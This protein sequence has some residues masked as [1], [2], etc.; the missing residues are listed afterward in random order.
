MSFAARAM[1]RKMFPPPTTTPT[2]VPARAMAAISVARSLTRSGS[3]PKEA[4]PARASPLNFRRM[5]S[6]FAMAGAGLRFGLG[7]FGTGECVA[8]F[9]PCESR[10]RDVFA[11]LGDF[12]LDQLIDGNRVFLDERLL[13]EADLFVELG[14]AAFHDLVDHLLGLAF[15]QGAG[16]LD[17]L[18]FCQRGRGDIFL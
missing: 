6:Y 4:G 15:V 16:T 11:Q 13:V 18:L 2:W 1:P 9:E 10:D 7:S 12:G 17:F 8:D 5:R 14:H 3:I